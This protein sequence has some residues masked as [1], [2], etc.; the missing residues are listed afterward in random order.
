M[1]H[2]VRIVLVNT[3]HAGNIGATARAMKNMGFAELYLVQPCD[4]QSHEARARAS[5]ADDI[6]DNASVC[7]TLAQALTGCTLVFGTSSRARA[8]AWEDCTIR[9]AAESLAGEPPAGRVAF[10]FG[11]ERSGL[12]NDELALCHRR[13]HIPADAA[14]PSLNLAAAVQLVTY[15]LRM[16]G[17]MP[18]GLPG[19]DSPEPAVAEDMERFYTHLQ[20]TLE[21]LAFLD[22]D[23]PRLLMRRLRR[24]YNRSRPDASELRILRGILSATDKCLKRSSI[25]N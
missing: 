22:P 25:S 24:F 21:G 4:Y 18:T 16:S 1:K 23:N 5:G 7:E 15:E 11:R 9:Q 20:A 6:L 13:V 8:M 14:F 2:T 10:V 17:E 3:T 19:S 12:T